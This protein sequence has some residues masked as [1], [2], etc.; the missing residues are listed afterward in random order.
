VLVDESSS[1]SWQWLY[2]VVANSSAVERRLLALEEDIAD[3]DV[4]RGAMEDA[5]RVVNALARD[6]H[7]RAARA[8]EEA[9]SSRAAAAEADQNSREALHQVAEISARLN[10]VVALIGLFALLT[11]VGVG[12]AVLRGIWAAGP[13]SPSQLPLSSPT[14][15]MPSP[16]HQQAVA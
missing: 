3:T 13:S 1:V 16:Q 15:P 8:E 14:L 9:R 7:R 10:T 11:S 5:L 12:V 4:H 2:E 6:A